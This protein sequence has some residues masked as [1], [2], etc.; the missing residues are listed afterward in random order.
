MN[1]HWQQCASARASNSAPLE[2]VA[3]RRHEARLVAGASQLSMLPES[4]PDSATRVHA[5]RLQ[6]R[7]HHID[8]A[9]GKLHQ[10]AG[11]RIVL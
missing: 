10:P 7:R 2:G 8:M 1:R 6:P 11:Y 3:G 5:H 9:G 4:P